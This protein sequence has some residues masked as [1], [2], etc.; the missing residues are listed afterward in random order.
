MRGGFNQGKARTL[1]TSWQAVALLLALLWLAACAPSAG[2]LDAA[3]GGVHASP[4][5]AVPGAGPVAA[6]R[7][8]GSVELPTGHRFDGVEVGGL[9]GI[10]YDADRDLFYVISDDRARHGPARFYTLRL[11][12]QDGGLAAGDLTLQSMVAMRDCDGV[13]FA[14]LAVDPEAIRYRADVDTLLWADEAGA[15]AVREMTRDGRCRRRLELPGYY[16]PRQGGGPRR[17]LGLES[18]ALAP[19][20]VAL[21]TA[22]EN[23]LQQD[24]PAATPGTASAVRLLRLDATTGAAT[25][26]YVYRVDPVPF[27]RLL[28]VGP[29]TNGLV[30]LLALGDGRLLAVERAF[31]AGIGNA[32]RI[33]RVDTATASDVLGL[34]ALRG[35]DGLRPVAK[36]LLLDL[37]DLG[38][39][40]DNIEGVSL[41]P[42]LAN[43][44]RT[45]VLVSDNNFRQGQVTQFLAFE[46]VPSGL[47]D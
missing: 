4:P 14:A 18:L 6:L 15:M 38:I 36:Q 29:L 12:L 41:G 21:Y 26:E 42:R 8:I 46:V 19:D 45:L 24:G 47:A 27:E 9:S 30:E 35:R 37:G 32:I 10:D 2:R 16:A 40:L 44:H 31:A 11:A 5:S 1:R 25:A 43:G 34:A 23:A 22:V 33:Y 3:P 17:N 20:G 7:F 39:R 28:P 13:P